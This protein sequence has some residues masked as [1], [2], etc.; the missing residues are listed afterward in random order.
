MIDRRALHLLHPLLVLGLLFHQH[1]HLRLLLEY[2]T[3]KHANAI[4]GLQEV[5]FGILVALF[6][7]GEGL[8]RGN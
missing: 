7:N 8:L 6:S 3:L 2:L 1:F 4:L 5:L